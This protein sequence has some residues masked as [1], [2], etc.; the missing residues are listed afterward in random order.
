MSDF[1]PI[2]LDAEPGNDP[3]SEVSV[4]VLFAYGVSRDSIGVLTRSGI[5]T[6][7]FAAKVFCDIPA[8]TSRLDPPTL[9]ERINPPGM[10]KR[11]IASITAGIQAW[12]QDPTKKLIV[13]PPNYGADW[14]RPISS[15]N[16]PPMCAPHFLKLHGAPFR[17]FG[18][19]V[20]EGLT[21]R[22]RGGCGKAGAMVVYR[23]PT[24]GFQE[25]GDPAPVVEVG[26]CEVDGQVAA[27]LDSATPS[28]KKWGWHQVV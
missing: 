16:L 20:A 28:E 3:L 18:R 11:R 22:A 10:G 9:L 5:R 23:L 26:W 12:R 25:P 15:S 4:D 1:E 8:R 21:C 13:N 27:T 2:D 6:I 14:N 19:I 17:V 7:L 24:Q